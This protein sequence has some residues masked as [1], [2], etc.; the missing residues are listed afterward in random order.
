MPAP[1]ILPTSARTDLTSGNV[2]QNWFVDGSTDSSIHVDVSSVWNDYTG[3]GVR[4]GIFDSQIDYTH[5]DLMTAYD[6]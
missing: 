4:V 3:S 1:T 2:N 6:L 5:D